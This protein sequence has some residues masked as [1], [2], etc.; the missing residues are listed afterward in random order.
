MGNKIEKNQ[1]SI[2][3]VKNIIKEKRDHLQIELGSSSKYLNYLPLFISYHRIEIDE[4]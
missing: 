1:E 2:K 4:K 3:V